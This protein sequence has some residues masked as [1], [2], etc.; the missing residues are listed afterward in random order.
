MGIGKIID[1]ATYSKDYLTLTLAVMSMTVLIVAF[2]LT[3]W[4]RVYH[5]VTKRYTYNR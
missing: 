5:H 1:I 3:V 4:R 2:N